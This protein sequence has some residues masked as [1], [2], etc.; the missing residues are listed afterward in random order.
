MRILLISAFIFTLLAAA[1]VPGR[2]QTV[3]ISEKPGSHNWDNGYGMN[4]KHYSHSWLSFGFVAG[5]PDSP[6]ADISYWRSRNISYGYRYKRKYSEV[7]S[8]GF[9]LMASRTAFHP[10]QDQYKMVPDT[11]VNDREKLVFVQAGAGAYQRVNFGQRGDHI[12][13]FFDIGVYGGWNFHV[14]HITHNR[15]EGGERLRTRRT[16]MDYPETFEYGLLARLGSGNLVLRG[17]YRMSD[18]FKTGTGIP[19]LPRFTVGAEIGL[20]PF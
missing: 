14:R 12:G 5:S 15:E 4:R 18:L 17:T 1:G 11:V 8:G 16:R 13:R 6:G 2:S 20:H 7:F 9:E 3:I 10:E 19:E